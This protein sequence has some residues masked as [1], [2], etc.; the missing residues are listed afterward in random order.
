MVT[1][2]LL[3]HSNYG[4]S[5]TLRKILNVYCSVL[6]G[7]RASGQKDSFTWK[8]VLNRL[9]ISNPGENS[10]VCIH[11][12]GLHGYTAFEQIVLLGRWS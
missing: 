10:I 12:S 9:Y 8:M 11:S 1:G 7:D 3:T 6:I 2:V 5:T 4:L